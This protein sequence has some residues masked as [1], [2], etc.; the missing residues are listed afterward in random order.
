MAVEM[1]NEAFEP[2]DTKILIGL[3]NLSDDSLLAVSKDMFADFDLR[4]F[5]V[6][7]IIVRNVN[8]EV[9]LLFAP[10]EI[11]AAFG[12]GPGEIPVTDLRRKSAPLN[13][14]FS[15]LDGQR[16]TQWQLNNHP[17]SHVEGCAVCEAVKF[18][19]LPSCGEM[20]KAIEAKEAFDE[21]ALACGADALNGD[22]YWCSTQYSPDYMWCYD[23]V[24][25]S[26]AFWLCKATVLTIRPVRSASAYIE[27]EIGN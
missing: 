24:M 20:S 13:P 5:A 4:N 2:V 17:D 27:V 6:D 18:G 21:V 8:D 16:C 3:R 7:G 1:M 9:D 14:S 15:L 12:D 10:G 23:M 26:F 22:A 25:R 11:A 19:W